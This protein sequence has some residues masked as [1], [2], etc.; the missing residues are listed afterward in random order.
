MPHPVYGVHPPGLTIPVPCRRLGCSPRHSRRNL[1]LIASRLNM[2]AMGRDL[3][4]SDN[5][6]ANKVFVD[7]TFKHGRIALGIPCTFRIDHGNGASATDPQTIGLGAVDTDV[8]AVFIDVAT[9]G[10]AKLFEPLLK[11]APCGEAA[12]EIAA[13][14]LGLVAA[15]ENMP[16]GGV[17]ADRVG[18]GSLLVDY[19]L[20]FIDLIGHWHHSVR[21]AGCVQYSLMAQSSKKLWPRHIDVKKDRS[22]T[23]RWSDGRVSVYPIVYLRRMSPSA[24]ARDLREQM[25]KNPL[26]VLP[27]S[28][29]TDRPLRVE[30][31]E[32][33]GN[34]AVR[35]SFSDGHH[36]G[37][38]SWQYL[39]EIDPNQ[40]EG[41]EAGDGTDGDG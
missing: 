19:G 1:L 9:F 20:G 32:L 35:L 15:E 6:P 21:S 36:T 25:A 18:D 7:N 39:R 23:I 29:T 4:F 37:L 34:Y 31:V 41:G 28:A 38:Y 22:L 16:L 33:V 8:L 2:E 24:D 10:E 14:G 17:G 27:S 40:P 13:F 30:D 26:T 3:E 12:F 5:L 11:I